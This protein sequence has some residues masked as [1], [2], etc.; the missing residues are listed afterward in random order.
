MIRWIFN[1]WARL[2]PYNTK[3]VEDL[4]ELSERNTVYIIGGRKYPFQAA[5]VCPKRKCKNI[6]QV[7]ISPETEPHWKLTEH[8]NGKVSLT[9]SVHVTGM[10]CQCHYWLRRGVI[11]WSETPTILVPSENRHDS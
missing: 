4:P 3:W 7:D 1:L 11:W 10:P 6:V 2:H 5:I 9:P 8:S